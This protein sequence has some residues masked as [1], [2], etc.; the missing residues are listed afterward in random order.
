AMEDMEEGGR[1]KIRAEIRDDMYLVIEDNGQGMTGED[2]KDILDNMNN[3]ENLDR[4][5]IGVVNVNQR[6]KLRFGDEY[7]VKI[8]SEY[9]KGTRV[10]IHMP[11]IEA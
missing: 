8:T 4:T 6:I 9:G 2:L 5:H 11:L 3:F 10:E 1:I 7:G